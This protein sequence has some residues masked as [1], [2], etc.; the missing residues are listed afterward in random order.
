MMGTTSWKALER[1]WLISPAA[2]PVFQIMVEKKENLWEKDAVLFI[3]VG[4]DG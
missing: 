4:E 2:D 3:E 1:Q